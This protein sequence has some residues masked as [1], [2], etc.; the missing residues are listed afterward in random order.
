VVTGDLQHKARCLSPD[1]RAVVLDVADHNDGL[2]TV[3][4]DTQDQLRMFDD[5]EGD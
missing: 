1:A 2:Q 4:P 3:E 5:E